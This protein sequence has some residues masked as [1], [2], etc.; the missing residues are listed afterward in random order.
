MIRAF[1]LALHL[2]TRLPA[3]S[4]DPAPEPP[5]FGKSVLFFP[6]V[7]AL[8]GIL[9]IAMQWLLSGVTPGIAALLLL[10]VWVAVTGALHL[11]GLADVADAWIGGQGDRERTLAI[12]QDPRSGPMAVVALVLL[13][14]SKFTALQ[15][16]VQQPAVW[17][18]LFAPIV[19]R[20]SMVLL[21]MT[22]SYIR[23][24]GIATHHAHYLQYKHCT[25]WL[26]LIAVSMVL[27]LGLIGMALLG[28]AAVSVI[29]LRYR[30]MQRLAGITGDALGASCE[31]TEAVFLITA[32]LLLS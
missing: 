29:A 11:D 28:I 22:M 7:G 4:L 21:L 32:A 17:A 5:E 12:M 8:L 25:V 1:L 14:L 30:F 27:C 26:T 6:A 23:P 18:L 24:K 20:S 10:T 31:L 19:G 15:V 3:P 13:L 16:L 2:L 9:L